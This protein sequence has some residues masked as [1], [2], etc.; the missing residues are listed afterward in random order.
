[1]TAAALPILRTP[2]LT[3]RPLEI[4]DADA[5][6]DGVGNYDVAK[7]L[8]SLPYPYTR[9]DAEYFIKKTTEDRDRVWAITAKGRLIGVIGLD[10][11]LGYW[12]ARPA[13]RTGYGF[14]AAQAVVAHWFADP[15]A[16]NLLSAVFPGN[17]GKSPDVAETGCRADGG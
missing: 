16:E 10:P 12:L 4:T 6:V 5:L 13:W 7:W 2:R 9:S 3:L 14:E 17:V 15:A 8:S 11:H 1:M